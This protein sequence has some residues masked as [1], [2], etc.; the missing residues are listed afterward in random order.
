MKGKLIVGACVVGI[1]G[2]TTVG[3]VYS[4]ILPFTWIVVGFIQIWMALFGMWLAHNAR[5]R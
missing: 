1:F 5:F 2:G 3:L 4:G